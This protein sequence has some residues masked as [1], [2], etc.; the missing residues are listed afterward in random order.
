MQS[1]N[2]PNVPLVTV[3]STAI[4]SCIPWKEAGIVK[5]DPQFGGCG[6][7]TLSADQEAN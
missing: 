1:E 7:R 2:H 3:N 4:E 5:R 6:D